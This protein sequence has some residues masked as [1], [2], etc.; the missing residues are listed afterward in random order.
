MDSLKLKKGGKDT[1]LE[2]ILNK[3]SALTPSE[4]KKISSNLHA[5][6]PE[7]LGCVKY[8]NVLSAHF[9]S[10]LLTFLKNTQKSWK[11]NPFSLYGDCSGT[12][13]NNL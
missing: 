1:E 12:I 13:G 7:N 2:S 5:F 10:K 8:E 4:L 3:K 6:E 9:C 11:P